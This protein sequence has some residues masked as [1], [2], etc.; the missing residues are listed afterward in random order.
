MTI[1]GN[2][3]WYFRQFLKKLPKSARNQNLTSICS[4]LHYILKYNKYANVES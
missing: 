2:L 4:N 1:F 3:F